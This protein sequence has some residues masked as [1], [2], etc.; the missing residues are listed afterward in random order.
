MEEGMLNG[1]GPGSDTFPSAR[2]LPRKTSVATSVTR[3]VA[4]MLDPAAESSAPTVTL[5]ALEGPFAAT[6][7][8]LTGA[9]SG[10][11]AAP[12]D[13][14]VH[15]AACSRQRP[16]SAPHSKRLFAS[17]LRPSHQ[18]PRSDARALKA[19]ADAFDSHL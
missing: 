19:K 18:E 11:S 12:V 16:N 4:P 13:S 8:P 1:M 10:E 7:V 6:T 2:W 5:S 9:G 14:L 17:I 15:P 3:H